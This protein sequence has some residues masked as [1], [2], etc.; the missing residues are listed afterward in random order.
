[1][2]IVDVCAFYSPTG[3][4]VRTYVEHKLL[5][6]PRLGHR[7]TIVVPGAGHEVT[8]VGPGAQ[9]VSLPSPPFPL[10]RHYRYFDN[11]TSLHAT[12][13]T[14]EPDLVEASSPWSSA[15]MVGRWAGVAPRALVMH[16]DPLSAY[17]Y[18]WLGDVLDRGTIDRVF[19]SYWRH[20][21][22][23]NGQFTLAVCGN[24][25]LTERMRAGG[26]TC[27]RTIPIGV[28]PGRFSPARRDEALRATL[29]ERCGLP[30]SATLLLGVG[31]LAPEKRWGL[32]VDAV[33]AVGARHPVGLVLVGA[34]AERASLLRRIGGN[35]HIQLL[36]PV[37]RERL[38]TLLASGDAL[39]HGC[40]AE[41]SGLILAEASASGLPLVVPDEGGAPDHLQPGAGAMYRSANGRS[42]VQAIS[43]VL[44]DLASRQS[45]ARASA[46]R[47]AIMDDHFR[48]LAAT[49]K[50]ITLATDAA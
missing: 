3:G 39:V 8:Q 19:G 21:R 35:P 49:Y 12:L 4:G 46:T 18:R 22:R 20:L 48:R 6:L 23:L 33:T 9:I 29:L 50:Q 1:M 14:L 47:V 10:D 40:E 42:L 25:A 38:S 15:A 13:D 44:D 28:E 45:T 41:T 26:L 5:A 34:G 27:A 16:A 37:D 43:T 32:V 2:H 11:E 17:A 7:V 30:P 36:P 31:R 24:T